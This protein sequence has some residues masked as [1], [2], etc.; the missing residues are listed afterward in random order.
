MRRYAKR[1]S[2]G[3]HRPN[4]R[5]VSDGLCEQGHGPPHNHCGLNMMAM[6]WGQFVDHTITLVQT[7]SSVV[8]PISGAADILQSRYEL[9]CEGHAQQI[10]SLSSFIDASSVYGSDDSMASWLREHSGGRMKT[11]HYSYGQGFPSADGQTYVAGD[12]RATEHSLLAAVHTLFLREHNWCAA[13]L[14]HDHPHWDDEK[15]YQKC[16]AIVGSEIQ[17]ITYRHFLPSLLGHPLPPACYDPMEDPRV[18]NEFS[19]AAYRFGH[20][21]VTDVL[22]LRHP[23][24]GERAG[25]VE[26]R[27]A[28]F[29]ET[30]TS[31]VFTSHGPA[32]LLMGAASQACNE[33]DTQIVPALRN[34][35]FTP[36]TDPHAEPMDLAAMNIARGRDHCLPSYSH[37]RWMMGKGDV[38]GWSDITSDTGMWERMRGVYGEGGYGDMDLWVGVLAED[39][40][41][42]ACVGPTLGAMLK[43]QFQAIRNG[44]AHYYEWNAYISDWKHEIEG[45]SLKTILLRNFPEMSQH[46][47]SDDAFHVHV[48]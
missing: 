18:A 34:F 14:G 39:H 42:G 40:G 27:D 17:A 28:F 1:G 8:I 25:H 44:D 15:V 46:A 10:N 36:S 9:D 38:G 2:C 41:E 29:S 23:Q 35:L 48:Q 45:T 19:A 13:R 6:V 11:G 37:M 43:K 22:D 12:V 32:Y 26:L 7:N 16:R 47:L 24:S 33:I 4:P 5:H 31:G 20:S 30:P 21:M 3:T